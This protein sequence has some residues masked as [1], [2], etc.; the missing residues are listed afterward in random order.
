[1][2][3]RIYFSELV[4][5][6]PQAVVSADTRAG[7][8]MF[9]FSKKGVREIAVVD[10]E[11]RFQGIVTQKSLLSRIA[12]GEAKIT[13]SGCIEHDCLVIDKEELS[14]QKEDIK[15]KTICVCENGRLLGIIDE[16]AWLNWYRWRVDLL[17]QFEDRCSEYELIFRNYYDSI[18]DINGDGTVI[19]ASPATNRIIGK[20][21]EQV[22]GKNIREIEKERFYFPSVTT[23]VKR[24]KKTVTIV[25]NVE[26]AKKA[27]V[28]GVPV[29][30]EEGEMIRIIAATRDVNALVDSLEGHVG[31]ELADL[32]KRLHQKEQLAESY[33]SEIRKLRKEKEVE[34]IDTHNKE[35]Q[36]I[37]DVSKKI[38]PTD[39]NVL[40]LGESGTGKDVLANMIHNLS[41]RSEGPFIKINCGAI[42]ENI[43]ESEL[44]GYEPGAFTGAQKNGKV[45]LLEI[46]N[47]GTVFFNEIGE[48]PFN[49]QA[50]LLQAIQERKFMR[51]GGYTEREV[52]IRIISATNKDLPEAIKRKE[53]REDLYYRLNV[54]PVHIPPLRERKEDIP[55]LSLVFLRRF[56]EKYSRS[57]QLSSAA[58]R[59]LINYGWPGNVRELENLI[60]RLVVA[61]EGDT[62][63]ISDFPEH[64]QEQEKTEAEGEIT[65]DE[66]MT[67]KEMMDSVEKAVLKQAYAKYRS[68][69]KISEIMDVNQSTIARKLKKYNIYQEVDEGR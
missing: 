33:F 25:Q 22:V 47:G 32:K 8:L 23:M 42:P 45:G 29:F 11:K 1:M 49:L 58:M 41:S 63:M 10:E 3:E 55:E 21:P 35:M 59:T 65:F 52:D 46:A 37:L 34:V 40:I 24:M 36:R 44:F 57:K 68:T 12:A 67:L 28:T 51:V 27:V 6:P 5:T 17:K 56:N 38:A 62:I 2:K 64:M 13:A 18:Y 26:K 61:S 16:E 30:D 50:K 60:E 54:V 4:I 31:Q 19:Y 20:T 14:G 15:G 48:M 69:V 53:F 7:E 39:S 43:L 9:Q 66:G